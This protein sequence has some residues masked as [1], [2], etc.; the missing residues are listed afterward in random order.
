MAFRHGFKA[1]ANR[2]ALRVRTK[3]LLSPTAPIDP[4]EIC[5]L[6]DIDVV[7][8]TELDCDCSLFTGRYSGQ[9]SA[10]TLN[11][12]LKTVIVH[13]DTHHPYRQRS[14]ICHELSHSFL[15]HEHVP[16]LTDGGELAHDGGIEAEANFLAGCLLLPNE[17]ALHVVR[18]GLQATAQTIYGVSSPMLKYRLSV[19]GAHI[20]HQRRSNYTT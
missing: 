10:V 4:L 16:P 9:F 1:N 6:Y 12:G 3:L 5:K 8:M 15:G 7:K 13:N 14:N 18:N 2:I 17:A 11:S 19:S 20:V